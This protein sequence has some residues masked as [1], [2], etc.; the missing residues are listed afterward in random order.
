MAGIIISISLAQNLV[1]YFLE[2]STITASL[3]NK[4]S[5]LAEVLGDNST[6]A[7]QFRSRN[8]AVEV[9]NSLYKEPAVRSAYLFTSDGQILAEYLAPEEKLS[10]PLFDVTQRGETLTHNRINVH[11]PVLLDGKPIGAIYISMDLR[12]LK[13][14]TSQRLVFGI[15]TLLASVIIAFLL[16]LWCQRFFIEP[17]LNLAHLT[18]EIGEK[19]KYSLRTPKTS[20]DELGV[21]ADSFNSMLDDIEARDQALA[22]KSRELEY[23]NKEL[24]QFAYVISH[25]LKSPLVTIQGFAARF[26]KYLEEGNQEKSVDSAK[27]V[28]NAAKRMAELIDNVLQLSR[29]GRKQ[30]QKK[31]V[32]LNDELKKLKEDLAGVFEQ[33]KASLTIEKN[34]PTVLA[35]AGEMRQ[36]FQNLISNGIRYACRE[37][38]KTITVGSRVLGQENQVFVRDQGPGIPA[39][40]HTKIFQLFQRLSTDKEG[41]GLGLAI[42]AKVMKNLGGRAWVESEEGKGSTFWL[43]FPKISG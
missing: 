41:T 15:A 27:R 20:E 3:Q 34:L 12:E 35:D 21:L 32:D 29:I 31:S 19:K 24:E 7:L 1:F 38:G 2:V 5:V 25:D 14:R 13:Q 40:Y 26:M 43:A 33:A 36:V 6:S 8:D 9:L 28:Q 11:N 30:N 18:H 4:A 10:V 22:Q 16:T 23:S 17:I 42:V 37:P 39:E